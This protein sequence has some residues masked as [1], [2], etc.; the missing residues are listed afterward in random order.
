MKINSITT[1]KAGIQ[2]E[3]ESGGHP[4]SHFYQFDFPRSPGIQETAWARREALKQVAAIALESALTEYESRP[5]HNL[6][7]AL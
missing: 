4:I 6:R 1:T 5:F 2:I 7:A 3:A